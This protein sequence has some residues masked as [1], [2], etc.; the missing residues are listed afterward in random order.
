MGVCA[1]QYSRLVSSGKEQAVRS[2]IARKVRRRAIRA[3]DS[4][5]FVRVD[6]GGRFIASPRITTKLVSEIARGFVRKR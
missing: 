4:V 2:V 3:V 6:V 1:D 5:G